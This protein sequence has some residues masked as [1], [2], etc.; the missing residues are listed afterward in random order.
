MMRNFFILCA[1]ICLI[2]IVSSCGQ[3]ETATYRLTLKVDDVTAKSSDTL[4]AVPVYI[5]HPRDTLAGIEIH[6]RIE[7]NPNVHFATDQTGPDGLL[8]AADTAGSM[9]S[10]WE[11]IGV[12]SIDSNVY[13]VRVVALADWPNQTITPPAGPSDKE[14]LVTL[15][16]RNNPAV[17]LEKDPLKLNIAIHG[18][19]TSFADPRGGTVGMVT[20]VEKVCARYVGDSCAAWKSMKVGR[21]DTLQVNFS[22]GSVT[23]KGE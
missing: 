10:G 20:S 17:P 12:N 13:D 7:P 11:W 2:S 16:L 4:I 9:I 1:A 8:V 23:I 3:A 6:M 15:Y 22:G 21:L 14:R 18:D 5:S 19:K